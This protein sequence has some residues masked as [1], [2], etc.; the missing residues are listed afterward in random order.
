VLLVGFIKRIRQEAFNA[1][2]D[3]VTGRDGWERFIGSFS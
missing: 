2:P 1:C 3:V